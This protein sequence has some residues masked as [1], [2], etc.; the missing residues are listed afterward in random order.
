MRKIGIALLAGG[1]LL[2][3]AG[4]SMAQDLAIAVPPLKNQ[5]TVFADKG[6]H[7]L[8]PTAVQTIRLAASDATDK[9]TLGKVTLSGQAEDVARVKDELVRQGVRAD[10]IVMKTDAGKPLPRTGDGLSDPA[11]RRVT[12]QL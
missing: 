1:I 4:M 3:T 2:G 12:I 7:A 10:A 11:E 6:S 8:S 9:A 5:F